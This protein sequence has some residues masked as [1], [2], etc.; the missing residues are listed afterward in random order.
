M[1]ANG[2]RFWSFAE[3]AHWAWAQAGGVDWDATSR[4]LRLASV[5]ALPP[6]SDGAADFGAALSALERVPAARDR[7]GTWAW[8]DALTR[9][10]RSAGALP[11]SVALFEP[12]PGESPT[13]LCVG[14]DDVLYLALAGGIALVDLRA[15][16]APR[17]L[18]APGFTAWRL[19]ADPAGG[20][21][22]LDRADRRLARI[23]GLPLP[24]RPFADYAA[25]TLRPCSEDPSPPRIDLLDLDWPENA[26]PRALAVGPSGRVAIL[27][28]VAD[29]DARLLLLGEAGF[30]APRTLNGAR[31]PCSLAWQDE[32]HVALMLARADLREAPVYG[33]GAAGAALDPVG[34][35]HPLVDHDGGPFLHGGE[36]RPH[37]PQRAAA[38]APA[39]APP[40]HPQPLDPL[41]LRTYAREGEVAN[42]VV[43]AE[44]LHSGLLADSEDPRTDWHRLYVEAAIPPHCGIRI[45]LAASDVP[46]P[47]EDG[48]AWHPHVIGDLADG[49]GVP[50]AA[51]VPQPSELPLHPG[52]L[53]RP[54]RRGRA[55]LFTVLIQRAGLRVRRLTGRYLWLRVSLRGDGRSTPEI[56]ALRC[57]GSRFSYRD[58]YLPE[59]YRESAFGTEADERTNATGADFLDRLLGSF[60]GVLTPLEDRIAASWLLSDAHGTPDD[61]LPW[62]GT[63]IGM[64]FDPALST[65][66]R[67]RMLAA[68]PRLY[69]RRGTLDGLELALDVASEGMV[70]RGAIVV[71]EDFRLRRTLATILGADLAD[72]RD[73]LLPG[74]SVSG[75]SFVGDTLV[76]GEEG[77]A[78]FLALFAADLDVS[79]DEAAQIARFFDR[80][81][82]R[83]TVLLHEALP[84]RTMSLMR[85]IVE[86]ESP[87]HVAVRVLAASHPFLVGIAA[88]VGVDSFLRE[89][90]AVGPVTL[91]RSRL[92]GGDR[93]LGTAAL[94]P[95]LAGAREAARMDALA[96]AADAGVDRSVPFGES[97][98]L[99]GSGSRAAPG[100][101][102]ER[103]RWERL[104]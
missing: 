13:D 29:E 18:T 96:P 17:R 102:I 43:V 12:E 53:P 100:R 45:E 22:A 26:A 27:C 66:G 23:S 56:A 93:V 78:E 73:A 86:L 91:A 30:E 90:P 47:P 61:A 40:F 69:R 82:H 32:S 58:H 98:L 65:S 33:V 99:D 7:F 75:N 5:R 104:E 101:R 25:G 21:W 49:P 42:A 59:L 57:W 10:V 31:F 34:D 72:E 95:R 4:T 88:L 92:G 84:E 3:P 14:H 6:A 74:L 11:G 97:F 28:W 63:W 52:L 67:R 1:D 9:S 71:L 50:R 79:E 81:A 62:L 94:D 64:A 36:G 19:A 39:G 103:Y 48:G 89:A 38:D 85:R 51:W 20:V 76:L 83:A 44:T 87:A 24:E 55:G 80:L 60:E 37:Y 16:F 2:L 41:S 54:P 35:Y 8:W 70:S 68:A 15:R 77:H 46:Q